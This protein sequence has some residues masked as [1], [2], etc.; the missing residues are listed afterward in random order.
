[1][2]FAAVSLG[3]TTGTITPK[4]GATV[5]LK[6]L[7]DPTKV[8]TLANVVNLKLTAQTGNVSLVTAVGLTELDYT[9]LLDSTPNPGGQANELSIGAANASLTTLIIGDG[10]L[11]KLTVDNS[12]LTALTT[13]GVIITTDVKNNTA[14]ETFTMGHKHLD[15]DNATTI[16]VVG[17]TDPLFIALNMSSLRKVKHV[18]ITGN[19]SLTTITAPGVDP[20]AEPIAVVTITLDNNLTTGTY[21]KAVAGSETDPYTPATLT[22]E[23]ISGFKTMYDAYVAQASRVAG[24]VTMSIE[25]DNSTADITADAAAQAAGA[26]NQLSD[27]DGKLNTAK[28]VT[29][30]TD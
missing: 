12:T 22:G 20:L 4:A 8:T 29:L 25:I 18:N 3:T 10:G 7:N 11:G 26:N 23:S 30:L 1:M 14:L 9:G 6:S 24:T 21:T 27:N 5:H 2:T 15:G 19:T 16:S 13:A 17:N 28:E